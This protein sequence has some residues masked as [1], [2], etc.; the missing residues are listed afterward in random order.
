MGPIMPTHRCG[1][2]FVSKQVLRW[3]LTIHRYPFLTYHDKLMVGRPCGSFVGMVSMG[4]VDPCE[5]LARRRKETLCPMGAQGRI[6]NENPYQT[7]IPLLAAPYSVT[8]WGNWGVAE[9]IEYSH[10]LMFF[11]LAIYAKGFAARGMT[12]ASY[13]W[14]IWRITLLRFLCSS[15]L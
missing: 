4:A 13:D 5:Y 14:L 6:N 11:I 9:Y 2:L 3:G 10:H 15:V 8:R 12:L 7:K 1:H